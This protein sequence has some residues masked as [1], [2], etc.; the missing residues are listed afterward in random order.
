M[1]KDALGKFK[2]EPVYNLLGG[3]TKERMPIY[4]TT[5]RPDLAKEMGFWGAKFPLPHGPADGDAGMA[6]NVEKVR[7][8]RESVGPEFP[9][10]IDCYMVR[11]D[12]VKI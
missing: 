5:A 4:A 8:V 6:A 1:L 11:H 9:I 12:L 3:K 2:N 10:M 7:A